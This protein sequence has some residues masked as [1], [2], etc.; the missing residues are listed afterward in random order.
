MLSV[1]KH[2]TDN[3]VDIQIIYKTEPRKYTEQK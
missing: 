2:E 1:I 3:S